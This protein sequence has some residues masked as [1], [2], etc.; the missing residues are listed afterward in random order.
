MDNYLHGKIQST[1]VKKI[2][3][4]EEES[5]GGQHAGRQILHRLHAS[6]CLSLV[7][8]CAQRR[9][10]PRARCRSLLVLDGSFRSLLALDGGLPVLDAA[11][12]SHS[13]TLTTP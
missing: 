2:E 11:P 10:P 9:R 6:S 5:L 13:T 1:I 8:P 7:A 3:K 4:R 12:F